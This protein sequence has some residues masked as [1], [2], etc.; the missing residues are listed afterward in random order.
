MEKGTLQREINCM[1]TF[2]CTFPYSAKVKWGFESDVWVLSKEEKKSQEERCE[3][4]KRIKMRSA[5]YI[6]K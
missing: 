2:A 6:F 3:W 1:G 5:S 4:G